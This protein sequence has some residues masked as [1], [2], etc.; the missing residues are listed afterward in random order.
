MNKILLVIG[1]GA[2]A[3]V[4]LNFTSV[5][6]D[7]NKMMNPGELAGVGQCVSLSKSSLVAEATI[8][9][10]C[11]ED[12]HVNLFDDDLTSGRAGPRE[13]SGTV[14]W[15]GRVSNNT[16]KYVTTWVELG[17]DF[18]D[19][20]GEKTELKTE[21]YVWIEPQAELEFSAELRDIS[22]EDFECYDFCDLDAE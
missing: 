11:V 2:I 10:A 17:A 20:Q 7:M 19:A 12:F 16:S 14:Y 3:Y 1:A 13:R 21:Q 8:R 15:E 18:F 22:R 6:M 4:G 5:R 9:N